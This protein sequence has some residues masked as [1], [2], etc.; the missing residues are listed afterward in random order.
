MGHSIALNA[1]WAGMQVKMYGVD[2]NDIQNGI[3]GVSD[4]LKTLL[5]ND[6]ITIDQEFQILNRITGTDSPK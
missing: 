4:K 1:A 6:L 2:A 3:S 5:E